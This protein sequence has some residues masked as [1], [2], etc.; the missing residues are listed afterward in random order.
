[1]AAYIVR[2]LLLLIPNLFILATLTFLL[3]RVAPGDVAIALTSDD[4]QVLS[5][6]ALERTREQLGLN[7]PLYVQYARWMADMLRGDL[8]FSPLKR[9]EVAEILADK[10]EVVHQ[11]VVNQA[12]GR[13]VRCLG[14]RGQVNLVLRK[15]AAIHNRSTAYG[16]IV[17]DETNAAFAET[18]KSASGHVRTS[19]ISTDE[20]AISPQILEIA[21]FYNAVL[22]ALVIHGRQTRYRPVAAQQARQ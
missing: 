16:S 20:N 9:L 14:A 10:A 2:R 5:Q 17:A 22:G 6:E 19:I 8:G 4:G 7:D 18:R 11:V 1:M 21:I 15:S 13:V 12:M 3:V